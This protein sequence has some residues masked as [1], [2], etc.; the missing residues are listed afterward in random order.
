VPAGTYSEA[1]TIKHGLNIYGK[2]IDQTKLTGTIKMT[3]LTTL[4][5]DGLTISHIAAPATDVTGVIY[6]KSGYYDYSNHITIRNCKFFTADQGSNSI[7]ALFGAGKLGG[8]ITIEG[9][10]FATFFKGSVI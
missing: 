6:Q 8:D 5:L 7:P 2:G 4:L 3:G 1:L 9:S 10:R